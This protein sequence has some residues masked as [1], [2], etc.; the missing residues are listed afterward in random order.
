MCQSLVPSIS[1]YLGPISSKY[2]TE[3]G[4]MSSPHVGILCGEMLKMPI[5]AEN[6]AGENGRVRRIPCFTVRLG[7]YQAKLD[8]PFDRRPAAVDVEFAVDALGMRAHRAQSDH[9]LTGNLRPGQLRFEQTEN[10]KLALA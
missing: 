6:P 10:F 2:T 5:Q 7:L 9:E 3:C 1:V 4:E 8:C